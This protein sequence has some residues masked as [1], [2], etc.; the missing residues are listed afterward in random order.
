M[1]KK[2]KKK[3]QIGKNVQPKKHLLDPKYL[4]TFWTT[5]VIIILI[6]FFIINN[7]NEP[8]EQGPY[9]PDYSSTTTNTINN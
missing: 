6:I 8:A 2:N 9:P 3:N 1:S 5:L 4:N 7:T